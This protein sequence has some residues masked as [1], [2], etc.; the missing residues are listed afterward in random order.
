MK[1]ICSMF[2]KMDKHLLYRGFSIM[3]MV[4][5]IGLLSIL[6]FVLSDILISALDVQLESQS[7]SSIEQDG[8][9]VL[10]KLL[11]DIKQAQAIVTPVNIGD[12]A[13]TLQITEG[14]IPYT[15][16]LNNGNLVLNRSGTIDS[17]N[18]FDTTISNLSFQRL[19]N[20]GGSNTLQIKFTIASKTKRPSGYEMKDFQITVGLRPNS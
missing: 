8:R 6:L 16:S 20:T 17:L 11:Y 2:C 12:T 14:G 1:Q 5:Y 13:P 10:A 7:A 15:Y 18:G 9:Y 4:V 19:G 3:E